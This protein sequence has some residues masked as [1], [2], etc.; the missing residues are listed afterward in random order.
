MGAKTQ[1][2]NI[3]AKIQLSYEKTVTIE[4]KAKFASESEENNIGLVAVIK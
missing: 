4:P 3:Y 2:G 1:G